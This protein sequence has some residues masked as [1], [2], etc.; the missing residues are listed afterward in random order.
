VPLGI[1]QFQVLVEKCQEIEDM[2]NK[3]VNRQSG[4]SAG[5]PSNSSGQTQ[6]TSHNQRRQ[7]NKPYNRSQDNQGPTR[8]VNTG[9]RGSQSGGNL[10]CRRCG[11]EGHYVNDCKSPGT[12]CYN[13]QRPGH[14]ARDCKAP[15]AESS[16]DVAQRARPAARG[17]AYS[18][19]TG[20]SG[21]T[22]N[23]MHEDH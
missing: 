8:S 22:S 6:S 19:G 11:Q 16:A 21:K 18:M 5:G 1:R 3:R 20:V 17:G 4:F 2:R 15:R 9:T 12:V 13:C 23:A 7:G 10:T 14:F